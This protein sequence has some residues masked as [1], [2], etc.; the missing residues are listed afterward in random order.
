MTNAKIICDDMHSAL[1]ELEP[2]SVDA[3]VCDPPYELGFMGK[4][5][6]SSG[7]AFSPETWAACLRVLKPGGHLLAFGGTR[8]WHRIAVAIEDA[9]FDVRDSIAW[10]Y[11]TGFPKSLD[12]SKAIDK[13][14][15][16]TRGAERPH[17]TNACQGGH[18]CHCFEN[19]RGEAFSATKH[20]AATDPAT[21]NAR[22]WQGWGTALKPAFEPVI[23]ARKPLI[24][25]VAKNVLAHGTGAMNIDGCRV[26][27]D[28]AP[29]AKFPVG[30]SYGASGYDHGIGGKREAHTE[31]LGRWPANVVLDETTA[32]MLDEQSG[33]L[34]ARG[35]VTAKEREGKE[36]AVYGVYAKTIESGWVGDTGG[37]SRFFYCAKAST[38]ERERGLEALDAS[39]NGRRNIHPTVKPIALM[40]YLVRLVTPPGGLVLDPFA[41]SGTTGVAAVLEGF[42][43]LGVEMDTAH[44]CI[45]WHRI[46]HAIEER[47]AE[48]EAA[49]QAPTGP[50]QP[51]LF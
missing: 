28:G 2:E 19:E 34:R 43:F 35:N 16:A 17:P 8:T 32:E 14:H 24:G 11:G 12:V 40:R 1:S 33:E 22:R 42:R 48:F 3:I 46:E 39:A 15:G 51:S 45:A 5:W 13:L 49:A 7:V 36:A 47:R 41:G 21:D 10:M 20:P 44:A 38:S 27:T 37:A 9:G 30:E 23:V 29:K 25:T 6:D 31:H 26:S 4:S 50:E 18:W